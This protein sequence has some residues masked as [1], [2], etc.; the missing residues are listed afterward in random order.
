MQT[1]VRLIILPIGSLVLLIAAS[2]IPP[3]LIATF[4]V[5][6]KIKSTEG[7]ILLRNSVAL[8]YK[9][10]QRGKEYNQELRRYDERE[11]M[12]HNQNARYTETC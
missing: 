7:E 12:H 8:N 3:C 1:R 10:I 2:V 6:F 4:K 11:Y 5:F 9:Y